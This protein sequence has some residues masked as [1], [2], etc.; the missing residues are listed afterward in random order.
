LK[1]NTATNNRITRIGGL[2]LFL[3]C[4]SASRAPAQDSLPQTIYIPVTFYDF[5]SNGSNPEFEPPGT[6]SFKNM[7]ADT[8]DAERKPVV[9]PNPFYDMYVAK[10]FRQWQGG[11][12]TI[13]VYDSTGR[14]AQIQTVTYDT[15]FKNI[16]FKDSLPFSLQANGTY[17]YTNQ[18]FFI[19]DNKGFGSEGRT[20]ANG[21]L[22]NFSFTMELHWTFTYQ[23]GLIFNF[24]GDDDVWVFI[25]GRKVIDLGGIHGAQPASV[26]LDTLTG[27]VPGKRYSFDLFYAERHVVA[28]DIKITTNLFNPPASLR[29]YSQPG[30]P[31]TLAPLG[32][33]GTA[34]AGQNFPL[35]AHVFDSTQGWIPLNDSLVTWSMQDSLGNPILSN[36]KGGSTIFFP[37]E[38]FGAVTITASFRDP[39]TG[40]T[41]STFI[42]VYVQPGPAHHIMIE[43]DQNANTT[44]N[45]RPIKT[46]FVDQA[47]PATVYAV[48]RDTFG[49]FVRL[50]ANATW[51]LRDTLV[52][53]LSSLKGNSTTLSEISFG[54][55]TL[56]ASEPG[57]ISC[58]TPVAIRAPN[59]LVTKAVVYPNPFVPNVSTP[60]NKG[61][62]G[63]LIELTLIKEL[64]ASINAGVI[65]KSIDIFDAVG[66][67]VYTNDTLVSLDNNYDFVSAGG[68]TVKAR[69]RWD[70]RTRKGTT[71]SAGT[72]IARVTIGDFGRNIKDSRQVNIGIKK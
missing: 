14:T 45:D 52:V 3:F 42:S 2:F 50:D 8:L 11:D 34:T 64:Q 12:F 28:S 32:P 53:A 63:I 33:A 51:V 30:N 35:Y 48:V 44:R 17:Q 31:S 47:N 66:N 29:L 5:H 1:R 10:W 18:A 40:K 22:H 59:S 4:V 25:N 23:T 41:I 36:Q 20:D 56:T 68:D 9:G 55:T 46:I 39:V 65:R 60:G 61:Q 70:G 71:A 6:G 57:V 67:R 26:N 54:T 37:R 72:Y 27:M 16:M 38:A 13:P 43:A 7:V 49:N 24:E 58:T 15:A 19:L 21:V 62:K 69:L